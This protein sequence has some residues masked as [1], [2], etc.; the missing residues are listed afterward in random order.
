MREFFN[1]YK[2]YIINHPKKVEYK[3]SH[4]KYDGSKLYDVYQ[5]IDPAIHGS[6][7]DVVAIK[8]FVQFS[9][10]LHSLYADLYTRISSS[11][12]H[13]NLKGLEISEYII[14][15]LNRE[16]K[17]IW[18]KK[19]SNMSKVDKG[20]YYSI[21]LLNFKLESPFPEIGLVDAR[22]SLESFT[23][24]AN[25]IL[26]Y[27]RYFLDKDFTSETFNP[28]E[29]AGRIRS[30]MQISQVAVVIKHSYD[31]ILYNGG[32]VSIDNLKKIVTF[33]YDNYYNLKLLL[34]GDMM[35]S[36]RRLQVM[37]QLRDQNTNLRLY[38]YVT[39]YRIKRAKVT[40]GCITLDFGQ[41]NPKE[42]KQ[43]VTDMQSAI[44]AYYEFLIG[45]TVL[46]NFGNST[47]D[48]VISVW[49][50]IQYIALYVNNNLN[51]D[52]T[53]NTREDFSSVPSKVLKKDLVVYIEKLTGIKSKKIKFALDAM[54][55]NWM[56]FNDIWT[57]MLY[58][59]SEFYLLPFF[60][61]MYSSPY[62]VIDRLLQRGGF[63]LEDR[64]KQFEKYLCNKLIH[65]HT[66]YPITCMPT[67]KYG[68]NGNEEE[69]DILVSMKNV[70][71]VADAKC[72]H[73]SIDPINYS[74]AWERLVDGCEQVIR[75][76][77]FI[78]NNKQYF[79]GLGDYS[80]KE[81]VPFV[82][83]NYPIFTGFSH[84]GVYIIDSHSFLSYM[85]C[86]I[87]TMRQLTMKGNPILDLKHY[88]H[89]EDQYSNNFQKY[90]SEN[91]MKQEF[92]K[93]IFIHDLP[94]APK[95]DGW[96]IISKSAQLQNN[97]IFNISNS[98]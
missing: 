83:T 7:E 96:E 38:K 81:F 94:L 23:D 61:I 40:R 42:H 32:F 49:C 88:Y 18:N 11:Y 3:P 97:P 69:I 86:G 76:I 19:Q 64:G 44:D 43:I 16:F 25:L 46:P 92:L 14:A 79:A 84:K 87:M 39:N 1:A 55:V 20:T 10:Y 21:D 4:S 78:K 67:G 90:L 82:V 9:N 60:P 70:I 31:D 68:S 62:N 85:L 72:I 77:D 37:S 28:Q 24:S 45:E 57:S 41:G 80:Y 75:K 48:E 2:Q 74:E 51:Y 8:D 98:Q 34:A 59:V 35:F 47:I 50:A 93:R 66:P 52:I 26:N 13:L 22:A 56:K 73:Y 15:G 36:E 65:S 33:D 91:P 89:N 95:I 27:L 54:E 29:F 30:S 71:L 5:K 12:K 63:N 58:P 6:E 53:I 17:V